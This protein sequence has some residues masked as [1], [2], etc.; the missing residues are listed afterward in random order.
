MPAKMVVMEDVDELLMGGFKDNIYDVFHLLQPPK[1]LTRKSSAA[2]SASSSSQVQVRRPWLNQRPSGCVAAARDLQPLLFPSCESPGG[3]DMHVDASTSHRAHPALHQG[4]GE[5]MPSGFPLSTKPSPSLLPAPFPDCQLFS[6][7]HQVQINL[8]DG[9][10]RG[11]SQSPAAQFYLAAQHADERLECLRCCH[12][13]LER[14]A[15]Q[16]VVFVNTR[17]EVT[18]S[19]LCKPRAEQLK[20]PCSHCRQTGYLASCRAGTALW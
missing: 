2:S 19:R 13:L 9:S 20:G 14:S 12:R 10:S 11:T 7:T 1:L 4:P 6:G 5:L 15:A 17:D 3:G 16:G 8:I 18:R